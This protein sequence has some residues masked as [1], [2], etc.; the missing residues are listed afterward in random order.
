MEVSS[1]ILVA[2][3][4]EREWIDETFKHD[5]EKYL[6]SQITSI[7]NYIENNFNG[8]TPTPNIKNN[9]SDDEQSNDQDEGGFYDPFDD[10]QL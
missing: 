7:V 1:M 5:F 3:S 8:Q 9:A 6:H 2:L 4:K 10:Q